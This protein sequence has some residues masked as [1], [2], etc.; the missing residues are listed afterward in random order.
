MNFL[1]PLLEG[2][3][4]IGSIQGVWFVNAEEKED[5]DI[6]KLK[7]TSWTSKTRAVMGELISTFKFQFYYFSPLNFKFC[8]F[9]HLLTFHQM[10]PLLTKTSLFWIFFS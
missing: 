6:I 9:S 10:L 5:K 2:K 8:Q 1:L 4:Q 7:R 3:K